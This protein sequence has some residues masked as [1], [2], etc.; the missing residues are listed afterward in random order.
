MTLPS[1]MK[2]Q[3]CQ[4]AK[5]EQRHRS[6]DQRR[7]DERRPDAIRL[8]V[9]I[10]QGVDAIGHCD[11]SERRKRDF[12]PHFPAAANGDEVGEHRLHGGGLPD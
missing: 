7:L 1:Y 3:Q 9:E 8:R 12:D 4:E 11:D 2:G 6:R 5:K 10:D